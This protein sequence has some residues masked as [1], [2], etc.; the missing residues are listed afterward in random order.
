MI[1]KRGIGEGSGDTGR[2]DPL[3]A[4]LGDRHSAT[5][6]KQRDQAFHRQVVK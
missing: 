6:H 5:A 2:I 1:G 4:V 3:S